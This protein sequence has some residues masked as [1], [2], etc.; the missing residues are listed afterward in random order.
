MNE[1]EIIRRLCLIKVALGDR[2]K[3]PMSEAPPLVINSQQWRGVYQD[4]SGG[5]T[6]EQLEID[7]NTIIAEFM[8]LRDRVKDWLKTKNRSAET[9]DNFMKAHKSV[10][11]LHD[12]G[13]ADKHGLLTRKTF[14]GINPSL[15][16]VHRV[17]RFTTQAKEGSM[18]GMT[19]GLDGATRMLGDGSSA[20]V[21]MGEVV[22][23]YGNKVGELDELF[24]DALPLWVSFLQSEG[25]SIV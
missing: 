11:L 20:V 12:L 15:R 8:G 10:S 16:S 19:I 5:K 6:S 3:R 14:S 1:N 22:D 9:V 21:L 13:N 25:L 4:F 23:E 7:A 24:D 18:V 17:G 2:T